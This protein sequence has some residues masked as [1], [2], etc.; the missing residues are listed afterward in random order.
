MI[1]I[2]NSKVH[3]IL[4]KPFQIPNESYTEGAK[5]EFGII[6]AICSFP[7]GIIIGS[8]I[9]QFAIWVRCK[10]YS[11]QDEDKGIDY[12]FYPIRIWKL[13]P[14]KCVQTINFDHQESTVCIAFRDN[15]IA[16]FKL[17]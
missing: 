8:D 14:K 13:E 17:H 1:T 4:S 16:T 9:G 12:L 6:T 11:K 5:Q 15:D 7:K 10:E 3:H 2:L